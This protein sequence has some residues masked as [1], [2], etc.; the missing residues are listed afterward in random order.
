MQTTNLLEIK[1]NE[2][3]NILQNISHMRRTSGPAINV[4][5]Y[6]SED[7]EQCRK[8]IEKWQLTSKDVLIG[9]FGESHRYVLAF[10][11]TISKKNSGFNYQREF[12]FEV[13]RGMSVLESV[14]ESLQMG[15][16][17]EKTE[18]INPSTKTPMIF[19]SHSSKDKPFVEASSLRGKTIAVK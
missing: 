19:I 3:K 10:A 16:C 12:I 15:I 8:A 14:Q 13:N 6:I 11:D 7:T 18:E 4:V 9:A 2:G 5:Y 1:I 17:L